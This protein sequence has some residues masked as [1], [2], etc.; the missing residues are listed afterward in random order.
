MEQVRPYDKERDKKTQIE[1]MFDNIAPA[2]D[3]LNHILSGGIDI[4]WRKKAIN[5][6]KAYKPKIFM[7]MATGTGDFAFEALRLKPE[8]IYAVDLSEEMLIHGRDKAKKKDPQKI[9][10][11]IKG[12]SENLSF[13]S[14]SID[15]ISVGFGVR[16][17][18]N[19]R[20][21]LLEM[22]RVLK[23]G[24][25]LVILE[26]SKPNKFPIKQIFDIYFKNVVPLIGK[27]ISNDYEAYKYLPNSVS[28]FP[29]KDEFLKILKECNYKEANWKPLTFG[30]CAM[31]TAAK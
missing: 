9:I 6:L 18:E 17:Y 23:P 22:N 2:Y 3:K 29:E 5:H 7:D 10:E 13:E 21:G 4:I 20:K 28:A 31:Y 25:R 1:Q 27:L 24:G 12:D 15:A 16:N 14:N 8:K 26:I 11:F 19:L 30:I